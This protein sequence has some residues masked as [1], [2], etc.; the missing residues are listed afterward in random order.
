MPFVF[1]GFGIARE[2]RVLVHHVDWSPGDLGLTVLRGQGASQLGLVLARRLPR[3]CRTW[4]SLTYDGVDWRVRPPPCSSGR[5]GTSA[6]RGWV[7]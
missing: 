2:G 6:P 1:E 7:T 4:G 5:P 3:A